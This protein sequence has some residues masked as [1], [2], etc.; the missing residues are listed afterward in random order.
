MNI[1]AQSRN[2]NKKLL[3]SFR[4]AL[5]IFTI[6]VLAACGTPP[7][8][9]VDPTIS[10]SPTMLPAPAFIPT[11]TTEATRNAT[12]TPP[13]PTATP[14]LEPRRPLYTLKANFNYNRHFLSVDET[15]DFTNPAG[16]TLSELPLAVEPNCHPGAFKLLSLKAGSVS[17]STY[18]LESNQLKFNLPVPLEPGQAIQLSLVYEL[19]L[20][21][22]PAPSATVRAAIFGYSAR[23][24]NLVDW[25][26]Y[27][28]PYQ[29]GK[30]WLIHNPWFYGEHQVYD[31]VDFQVD[32]NLLEPPAKLAVAAA[33][34]ANVE[35]SHYSFTHLNARNF[36]F[37]ASDLYTIYA[38]IVAGTTVTS[39]VFPF[40][41]A[42]G[43]TALDDAVKA[44]QVYNH[45]FGPYPHP[46]LAVVEADFHDGMEYD[47]LYFLS[48]GFYA[49]YDGT[50]KGYLTVIGVHEAA[51]Q[52]WYAR[53]ANDQALEPWLDEAMATYSE[54]LY[55]REVYP[56]LVNWW[57]SYRVDYFQPAGWVNQRI[58]D[59]GG[60]YPYRD[61][62]Y[63]RGARFL[64]QVRQKIGDPAFLD[65]LK[66]YATRFQGKIST[67]QDFFDLLSQ[68]SL[69]DFSELI[70]EYFKP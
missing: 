63:L 6:F 25:Y 12:P 18:T 24:A 54:L 30:G 57:W 35:G 53:V 67:R 27:L 28:P 51:H 49:T 50:P 36:T 59:Y 37:S 55:Y 62:V 39:Y 11:E 41:A 21:V 43:R 40:D 23:Q 64:D 16:H 4:R 61:G 2:L 46:S 66:D 3:D 5:F 44:L 14:P 31:M 13:L 42:G 52:W 48:K 8:S 58:Y 17:I 47:G 1:N 70:K 65:F 56:D 45:L 10:P 22:I 60:S 38:A 34:Q 69:A 29:P 32:L 26:P 33:A 7:G 20:P 9:A 19:Y 15:I 68:H